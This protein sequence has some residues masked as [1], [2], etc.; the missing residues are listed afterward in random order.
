GRFWVAEK[1]GDDANSSQIVG[2][3]ACLAIP[4]GLQLYNLYLRPQLRGTGAGRLLIE[5]VLSFGEAIGACEIVLWTDTRFERAH[6]FYEKI[7]FKRGPMV[8][9]LADRS[10][11]VEYFYRLRLD[12]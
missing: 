2:S 3:A 6:R 4:E 8:R 7:G 5:T 9:S 12:R 1:S 10:W 11:S